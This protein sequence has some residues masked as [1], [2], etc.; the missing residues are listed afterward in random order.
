MKYGVK[1]LR[2]WLGATA[3]LAAVAVNAAT[4]AP[5]DNV[6]LSIGD[7]YIA[8]ETKSSAGSF[9]DRYTFTAS[10]ELTSVSVALGLPP[11][12]AGIGDLALSWTVSSGPG[13]SET[14]TLSNGSWIDPAPTLFQGMGNGETWTLAVTGNALASGAG[15][16]LSV[17]AV[18]LPPAAIVFG[19]VLAGA[20]FFSRRKK[21]SASLQAMPA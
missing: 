19:S 4:I 9:E 17:S 5:G 10:E 21:K 6:S 13:N 8:A 16:N 15:Y 14:F 3:L 12:G 2:W 18:P 20:G 7:F 11:S 1:T